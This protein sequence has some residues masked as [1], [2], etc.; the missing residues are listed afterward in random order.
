[1]SPKDSTYALVLFL[2]FI[3]VVAFKQFSNGLLEILLIL[4]RPVSTVLLLGVVTYLYTKDYLY[5]SL[6]LALISVYLLKDLWVTWPRSD[7]RRLHLDVGRDQSRF[8]AANSIDIQWGSG[9]AKHDS[10]NMLESHSAPKMLVY[11]PSQATLKAM[12]D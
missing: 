4:T 10:P 11:P 7:A 6:I 5:T 9:L 12:C 3:G 1:M 8:E 2:L